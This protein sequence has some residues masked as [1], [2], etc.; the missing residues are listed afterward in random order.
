[1]GTVYYGPFAEDIGDH[2]GYA[3]RILPDGTETATWTHETREFVAYVARCDCGWRGHRYPPTNEGRDLADDDWEDNHLLPLVDKIAGQV[4]LTGRD[5]LRLS[6]ALR[7][8]ARTHAIREADGSWRYADRG[9]GLADA[10]DE[11]DHH[12]DRLH[13]S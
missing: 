13:Q 7:E 1:M 8:Q 12:L 6:R 11:I 5:L 3:A 9:L 4:T 2:E 10:A